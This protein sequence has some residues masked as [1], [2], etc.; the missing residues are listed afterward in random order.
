MRAIKEILVWSLCTGVFLLAG[1][2]R[3]PLDE[4]PT[5]SH[6]RIILNWNHDIDPQTVTRY[7]FYPDNGES[8][9]RVGTYEGYEGVIAAG[10]YNII[11]VADGMEGA[12]VSYNGNYLSD[13]VFASEHPGIAAPNYITNVGG[14][15]SASVPGIPIY[16]SRDIYMSPESL[17]KTL[18]LYV[19]PQ[20]LD[21]VSGISVT[22]GGIVHS[23]SLH[24]RK[25]R[26][27]TSSV[28]QGFTYNQ[29]SGYYES[30]IHIF[31]IYG[32]NNVAVTID[33]GDG[34]KETTIPVDISEE[35]SQAA[36]DQPVEVPL[37]LKPGEEIVLTVVVRGW[38]SGTGSGAV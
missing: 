20:E 2:T 18:S 14:V 1:C 4:W 32:E 34:E 38:T 8:F 9:E 23:V 30:D 37:E 13:Y 10:R 31:G 28:A 35:L 11:M 16:G 22:I 36:E 21:N 12:Q 24:D 5:E 25:P 33:Y 29:A 3:R 27:E 6:V 19:D 17:V 15:Y 26:N 7:Y